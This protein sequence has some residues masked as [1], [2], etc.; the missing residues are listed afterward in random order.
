M[1]KDFWTRL[2]Q[3][4]EGRQELPSLAAAVA[5]GDEW[6]KRQARLRAE[7]AAQATRTDAALR[8]FE[9]GLTGSR[10]AEIDFYEKAGFLEKA[11]PGPFVSGEEWSD[12]ELEAAREAYRKSGYQ[13]AEASEYYQP[14]ETLGQLAE[15]QGLNQP[16]AQVQKNLAAPPP[17]LPGG[18]AYER[19]RAGERN[20]PRAQAEVGAASVAR[21]VGRAP[22]TTRQR[23]QPVRDARELRLSPPPGGLKLA[24]P[25]AKKPFELEE[26]GALLD[27]YKLLYGSMAPKS[28]RLRIRGGR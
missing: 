20:L 3:T 10:S 19:Y 21:A 5:G 25:K 15:E 28:L 18:A 17:G 24:Y 16:T 1:G 6:A 22:R 14:G 26:P 11:G 2:S 4:P 27:G 9:E 7:S 12:E 23:P 13:P 8:E